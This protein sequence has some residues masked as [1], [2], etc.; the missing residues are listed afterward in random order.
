MATVRLPLL[1]RLAD[2]AADGLMVAVI[3]EAATYSMVK[4]IQSKFSRH[5]QIVACGA[6]IM[7]G[8]RGSPRHALP[9]L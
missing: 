2:Q 8:C 1:S 7:R 3:K 9:L 5:S 4:A 6:Q